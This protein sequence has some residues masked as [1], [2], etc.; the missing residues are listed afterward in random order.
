M[1]YKFF[2]EKVPEGGLT[3][4]EYI[5]NWEKEIA[6]FKAKNAS[7]KEKK[8]NEY[9]KLN[10]QRTKRIEKQYNVSDELKEILKAVDKDQ[11]WLVITENWCGDSAQNLPIIAKIADENL[12]INLR[13]IGRDSHLDIMDNFLTNGARSIPK[14]VVFDK[15]GNELFQWGPRPK[16]L[17]N[18]FYK[19]KDE[20]IEKNKI[21]AKL[22]LWY[23]KY[24]IEEIEKEFIKL[25]HNS[26]HHQDKEV[27]KRLN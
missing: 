9:K 24:G 15:E 11:L 27:H 25:I 23:P 26:F 13:I 5:F 10:L 17:Q 1:I 14:L 2:E 3:Y 20:G 21:Y 12:R 16:K 19:L 6:D 7:E 18:L 22:H 8:Y 4:E